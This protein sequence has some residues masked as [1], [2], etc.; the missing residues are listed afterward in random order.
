[1]DKPDEQ[2]ADHSRIMDLC[3]V[4]P[5][6]SRAVD[7][8]HHARAEQHRKQPAHFPVDKQSAQHPTHKVEPGFAAISSRA[9]IRDLRHRKI[10]DVHGKYRHNGETAHRVERDVAVTCRI[11]GMGYGLCVGHKLAL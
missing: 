7:D 3:A 4:L 5:L 2:Q 11:G 10:D 1:M 9:H 8:Q 6:C